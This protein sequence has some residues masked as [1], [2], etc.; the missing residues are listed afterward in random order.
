M[1]QL[2]V[3]C[4]IIRL[5]AIAMGK[6]LRCGTQNLEANPIVAVLS[7]P[8][9][10]RP[11]GW[12][13]GRRGVGATPPAHIDL[14]EDVKPIEQHGFTVADFERDEIQLRMFKW[15]RHTDTPESIDALEP[16]HVVT[17]PRPG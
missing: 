10:T 5:H 17:F 3:G 9:G 1:P 12:P 15:D 7:G 11:G 4:C 6:M 8:I 14:H 13:S 2:R 16:F